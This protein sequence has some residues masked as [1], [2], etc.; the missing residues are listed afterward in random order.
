V[1]TASEWGLGRIE[2]R[3]PEG[4]EQTLHL[5]GLEKPQNLSIPDGVRV[6]WSGDS[7]T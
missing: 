1:I 6:I 2:W 4:G 5:S 3:A 7:Q